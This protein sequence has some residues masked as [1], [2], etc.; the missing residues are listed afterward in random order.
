LPYIKQCDSPQTHVSTILKRYGEW[1]I[2]RYLKGNL[3]W[4]II[5]NPTEHSFEIYVDADF[6]GLLDEE[7]ANT[8][9]LLQIPYGIRGIVCRMSSHIGIYPVV[10][11]RNVHYRGGLL[12]SNEY[13]NYTLSEGNKEANGTGPTESTDSKL[14][15]LQTQRRGY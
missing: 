4:G 12:L 14:Q 15:S 6:G 5:M 9:Q 3:D 10:V 11:I 7:T 13:C 2:A 8:T 1:S